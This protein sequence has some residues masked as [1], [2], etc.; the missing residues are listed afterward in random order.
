MDHV[1]DPELC[2]MRIQVLV[3]LSYSDQENAGGGLGLLDTAQDLLAEIP[4][5]RAG[6]SCRA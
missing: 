3:S 4:A 2:T 1:G 5:G 6:W